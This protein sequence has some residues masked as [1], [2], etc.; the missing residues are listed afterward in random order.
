MRDSC[1]DFVLFSDEKMERV[2]NER[3]KGKRKKKIIQ[4]LVYFKR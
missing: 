1:V 2:K 4:L 3:E